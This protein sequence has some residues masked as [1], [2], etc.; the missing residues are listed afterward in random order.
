MNRVFFLMSIWLLNY[1]IVA[2]TPVNDL[3]WQLKWED[4]F[5]TNTLNDLIWFK[6]HNCDHI[7][8]P[9]L[10]LAKNVWVENHNL[11]LEV[12]TDKASCPMLPYL[13]TNYACETCNTGKQY[14]YT[15]GWI[16]TTPRY[17]TQFGYIEAKIKFPFRKG[18]G[19]AFWVFVKDKDGIPPT[20]S[21]EIDIFETEGWHES[22]QFGTHIHLVN[23][24]GDPF[25][26][27]HTFSN[28]S[29]A[30]WNTYAVEWDSERITWY[31]N[32]KSFRTL[33]HKNVDPAGNGIIDPVR[34]IFSIG[35]HPEKLVPPHSTVPFQERMYVDYIKVYSLKY[36]CTKN[37]TINNFAD[38]AN[39][40]YAVK[41]SITLNGNITMPSNSNTCLRATD[42]I[43]LLPGFEVPLGAELY[44][45]N[46]PCDVIK[47]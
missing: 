21:A 10:H 2:Q 43:E 9:Y 37:V 30:N 23:N 11:V 19:H 14:N 6:A 47:Q 33:N 44:L 26:Q 45:N 29:Y 17:N 36:D 22:N 16:N 31:L 32:G 12:N 28:Y 15:T 35:V 40:N 25:G 46:T 18:V 8:K 42:Y 27:Q 3:H 38:F 5:I 20:N 34:I 4:H 24:G 1:I 13:P 7:D 39:Y 41:K